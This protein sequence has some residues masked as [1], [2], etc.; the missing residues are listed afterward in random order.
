MNRQTVTYDGLARLMYRR[1]AAGVLNK[2]LGHVAY[3]CIDARLP[4]LTAIVVNSR[5][6]PGHGIPTD[7]STIDKRREK[8]YAFDWYNVY[9]PNEDDLSASFD[10]A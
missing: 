3:Y 4:P 5:G 7:V 1:H 2:I 10:S 9:P 6:V 8:V